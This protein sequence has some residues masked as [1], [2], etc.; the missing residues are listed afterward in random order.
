MLI[1]QNRIKSV[2]LPSMYPFYPVHTYIF[3]TAIL[4]LAFMQYVRSG[5]RLVE[6]VLCD[7]D[8]I[9]LDSLLVEKGIALLYKREDELKVSQDSVSCT[10]QLPIPHH[11]RLGLH[12][13]EQDP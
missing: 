5:A 8:E 4:R 11:V 3:P 2:V 9:L 1:N 7:D 6:I 10:P 12:V 13:R